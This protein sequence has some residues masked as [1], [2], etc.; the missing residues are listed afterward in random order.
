MVLAS[1]RE[2]ILLIK[3]WLSSKS[4]CLKST[5][6]LVHQ[7]SHSSLSTSGSIKE[8]SAKSAVK[9]WI[10]LPEP[11]LTRSLS[12]TQMTSA[13]T[14][15]WYLSRPQLVA[16]SLHTSTLP[17]TSHTTRSQSRTSRTSRSAK[18]SCTRTG[19]ARSKFQ[20]FVSLLI[21]SLITTSRS[22]SVALSRGARSITSNSLTTRICALFHTTY[23][24]S[25]CTSDGLL[26]KFTTGSSLSRCRRQQSPALTCIFFKRV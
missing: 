20:P 7:K 26:I 19:Q 8:C 9:W 21:R 2:L 24:P 18:R 15:S 5:T 1:S 23:E 6:R 11:S 12:R 17:W 3:R 14:S 13:L 25:D 10:H 22:T 16:S 4:H